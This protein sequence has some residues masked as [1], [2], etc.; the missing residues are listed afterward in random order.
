MPLH[1]QSRK[2]LA[3]SLQQS[4]H[5]VALLNHRRVFSE[6]IRPTIEQFCIESL[7]VT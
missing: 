2:E 4:R 6:W 1:V 7:D 5:R 3:F